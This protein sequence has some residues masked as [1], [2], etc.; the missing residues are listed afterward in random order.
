VEILLAVI[1]IVVLFCFILM[2][3][4]IQQQRR[5]RQDISNLQVGDE[6]LTSAGFLATVKEIGTPEEGPVQLVLDLG[7]GMEVWALTS[8]VARRMI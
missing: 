7:G 8:A 4:V 2:R 6:V 3:P 5:Q 1:L